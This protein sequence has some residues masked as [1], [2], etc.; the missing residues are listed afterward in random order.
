MTLTALEIVLGIVRSR[1]PVDIARRELPSPVMPVITAE[2]RAM[3]RVEH[4]GSAA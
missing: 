2:D 1:Q 3:S 4:V